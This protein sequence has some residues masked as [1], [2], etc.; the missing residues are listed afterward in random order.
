MME[1]AQRLTQPF[2]IEQ[3]IVECWK[4]APKMFGLRGYEEKHVD[5]NAVLVC[6]YHKKHGMISTGEFERIAPKMYRIAGTKKEEPTNVVAY[7]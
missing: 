1:A 7:V 3:L 4:I 6:L 2:S 5:S